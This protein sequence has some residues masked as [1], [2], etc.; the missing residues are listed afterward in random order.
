MTD[1]LLTEGEHK[2]LYLIG[3][4]WNAISHDVIADGPTRDAD[5]REVIVHVHAL[6]AMVMSQAAARAY[7]GKFRLLGTSLHAPACT[8]CKDTQRLVPRTGQPPTPD[9]M[10]TLTTTPCP[11]CS[12]FAAKRAAGEGVEW[13]NGERTGIHPRPHS[14]GDP[15]LACTDP[16]CRHVGEKFRHPQNCPSD[17]TEACPSDVEW[18]SGTKEDPH[19]IL[20]SCNGNCMLPDGPADAACP[21]HGIAAA[22]IA[23][24]GE[25]YLPPRYGN[26]PCDCHVTPGMKHAIACCDPSWDDDPVLGR[27]RPPPTMK[28]EP[29]SN[30][31]EHAPHVVGWIKPATTDGEPGV[32]SW[33]KGAG[34]MQWRGPGSLSVPQDMLP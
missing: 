15:S 4:A 20:P 14:H 12:P 33:C 13:G 3:Q 6:Q 27:W 34:A 17:L 24:E 16:H 2:A 30:D 29:C 11:D 1:E 26:C 8:R 32:V 18:R 9:E 10:L 22:I 7:P 19:V 31:R 28:A 21:R 25:G 23:T 5:C